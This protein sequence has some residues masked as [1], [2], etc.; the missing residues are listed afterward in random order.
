MTQPPSTPSVQAR[1]QRTWR[2]RTVVAAR[3]VLGVL[4]LG[5]LCWKVDWRTLGAVLTDLRVAA[6]VGTAL[7]GALQLVLVGVR[8]R[9]LLAALGVRIPLSTAVSAIWQGW[10]FSQFLP[11]QVGGDVY[12]AY[13]V[14]RRTSQGVLVATSVLVD[15]ILGMIALLLFCALG[16][17]ASPSLSQTRAASF[18]L[19]LL[20][21]LVI[22]ATVMLFSLPALLLPV[23]GE[24]EP[25]GSLR[26]RFWRV[27]GK[28]QEAA[29]TYQTARGALLAACGVS[30]LVQ[31][32]SI[33]WAYLAFEAVRHSISWADATAVVNLGTLVG[34]IPVSIAGLGVQEGTW[35]GLARAVGVPQENALA[36]A[37]VFRVSRMLLAVAGGALYLLQRSPRQSSPDQ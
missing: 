33:T 16:A 37:L 20:G 34:M 14:G 2:T 35:V 32:V 6:L 30:A 27:L 28:L 3:I 9:I 29:R 1:A 13:L 4:L 26:A 10:F 24:G 7:A 18:S 15:R 17:A 31:V 19:A 11:T 25:T 5:L 12:R 22:A 36:A 23:A 21:A 8:W